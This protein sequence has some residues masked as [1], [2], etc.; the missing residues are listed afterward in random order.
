MIATVVERTG[1]GCAEADS[2]L[3]P[4]CRSRYSQ[5]RCRREQFFYGNQG[6]TSLPTTANRRVHRNQDAFRRNGIRTGISL[7]ADWERSAGNEFSVADLESA[8]KSDAEVPWRFR[9][10]EISSGLK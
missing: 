5:P 4:S 1:G 8:W 2:A 3:K 10:A 9:I 6:A 7:T